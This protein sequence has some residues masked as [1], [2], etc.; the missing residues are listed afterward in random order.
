MHE[1]KQNQISQYMKNMYLRSVINSLNPKITMAAMAHGVVI[2]LVGF[3]KNHIRVKEVSKLFP[4]KMTMI[5]IV[6]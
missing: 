2:T 3:L 1:P 6:F 5:K 4:S